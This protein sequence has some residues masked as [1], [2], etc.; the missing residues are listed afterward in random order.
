MLFLMRRALDEHFVGRGKDRGDCPYGEKHECDDE[1]H[2]IVALFPIAHLN[3]S[4]P[5]EE[6]IERQ[7]DRAEY[8]DDESFDSGDDESH[9]CI[10]YHV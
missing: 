1:C 3:G 2:D 10:L 7:I 8:N 5:V 4:E 9:I 6:H